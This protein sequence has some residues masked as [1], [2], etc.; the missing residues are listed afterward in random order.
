MTSAKVFKTL[1]LSTNIINMFKVEITTIVNGKKIKHE[2]CINK[3]D[4]VFQVC[5]ISLDTNK[6]IDTS[7]YT[8]KTV[9]DILAIKR[10]KDISLSFIKGFSKIGLIISFIG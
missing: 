9:F 8:Y 7:T 1:S 4:I 3:K 6:T 10:K 2:N 5:I